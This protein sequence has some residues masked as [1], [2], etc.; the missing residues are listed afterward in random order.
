M[1]KLTTGKVKFLR[2]E[3]DFFISKPKQIFVCALLFGIYISILV[4]TILS[5]FEFSMYLPMNQIDE[6]Y[7]IW[8]KQNDEKDNKILI[9]VQCGIDI[10][11]H[12][13]IIG[14]LILLTY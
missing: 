12:T 14:I 5:N 9:E 7:P 2:K 6:C 1:Q 10:V 13:I 3:K 8:K 11:Y 4:C